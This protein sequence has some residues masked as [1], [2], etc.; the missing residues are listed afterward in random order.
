MRKKLGKEKKKSCVLQRWKFFCMVNRRQSSVVNALP[1]SITRFGVKCISNTDI[2]SVSDVNNFIQWIIHICGMD[3][4]HGY[5]GLY[6][7]HT[8]STEYSWKVSVPLCVV[9][10]WEWSDYMSLILTALNVCP[11]PH[12]LESVLNLYVCL[13]S[14]LLMYWITSSQAFDYDL[15]NSTIDN[16]Y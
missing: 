11:Y 8:Y 3:T 9:W 4:V 10:V 15:N 12:S 13:G 16:Y 14:C 5:D 7:V 1:F 6:K 2:S